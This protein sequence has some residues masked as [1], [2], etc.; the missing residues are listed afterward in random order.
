MPVELQSFA[1]FGLPFPL[2]PVGLVALAPKQS[3]QGQSSRHSLTRKM[4]FSSP[5]LELAQDVSH[6]S[7]PESL[8]R[9]ILGN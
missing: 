2:Q 1:V 6:E 4:Y 9:K 5:G 3:S 7:P 8:T